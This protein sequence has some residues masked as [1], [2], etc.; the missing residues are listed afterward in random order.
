MLNIWLNMKKNVLLYEEN[1]KSGN[2]MQQPV[3]SLRL[4]YKY[5]PKSYLITRS[6]RI[7]VH[8]FYAKSK[9]DKRRE[10]SDLKFIP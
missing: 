5:E 7:L 10:L 2:V 3:D 9:S 8:L 4:C 6:G 1:Q